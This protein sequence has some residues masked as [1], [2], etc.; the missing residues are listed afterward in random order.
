[1]HLSEEAVQ[2]EAR[3]GA[4]DGRLSRSRTKKETT[5]DDDEAEDEE[6]LGANPPVRKKVGFQQ[7][8]KHS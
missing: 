8:Y 2:F 4:G 5:D 6:K 7:L 3:R 1:M